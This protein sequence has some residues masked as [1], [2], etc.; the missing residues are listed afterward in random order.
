MSLSKANL[1][2]LCQVAI[3]AAQD[4]G[5][6][7]E[8][9]DRTYLQRQFKATG[10]SAASQIVT[11][12][13]LGS[14]RIIREQ[15]LK[16]SVNIDIAFVGEESFSNKL[17][18][19][20]NSHHERF[21]KPYFWC[22]DPLDG[23]LAFSQGR[24]GYAVSIALVEQSG[25]PIIGVVYDPITKNLWHAING[26]GCYL[27]SQPFKQTSDQAGG[28]IVYADASFKHHQQYNLAVTALESCS[29]TLGLNGVSFIFGN[30][31]VLNACNVIYSSQACYFK[32]PKK[33]EGGGS[34]WDFAATSCMANETNAIACDMHGACLSL[35][36]PGSTFMNQ[37][38]VLYASNQKIAD[39][40]LKVF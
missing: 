21:K 17:T 6:W 2:S 14:E 9:Y 7:I 25:K 40:L 23:T 29:A 10:S 11:D 36:D 27:N 22:V 33:E 13:D 5:A 28:L 26:Y 37:K 19:D 16:H 15:L 39:M 12:V 32:L 34:L 31:A 8:A 35:N 30:G 18:S 4:A 38:G 1:L 24:A 20:T 3:Q